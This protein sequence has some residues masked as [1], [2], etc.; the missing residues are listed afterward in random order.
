MFFDAKFFAVLTFIIINFL[1]L[2]VV[3]TRTTIIISLIIAHLTAVLFFSLSIA[4]YNSFKE[5]VLSLIIYSM[6]ILFLISNYSSAQIETEEPNKT[7]TWSRLYF[8]IPSLLIATLAIF[9]AL[10]S[11]TKNIP[12]ISSAIYEKASAQEI[13]PLTK[14]ITPSSTLEA[15]INARKMTRFKEKLAD[16]FLLKRSSDVILIIVV[17]STSLLILRAQKN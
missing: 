8:F 10:V 9:L 13:K 17:I 5:I 7:R 14:S 6:V 11:I 15:E 1:V 3:R 12:E 2:F 4:N 16:N